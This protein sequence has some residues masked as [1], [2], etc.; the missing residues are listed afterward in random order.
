MSEENSG[1]DLSG[2]KLVESGP[3][4][5]LLRLPS[6][7]NNG[8]P[9]PALIMMHGRGANQ[10]DIY[11]LVPYVDKRVLVAAPRAPLLFSDDPRGSFMW[12]ETAGPGKAAPGTMEAAL[13]KL[14]AF[15]GQLEQSAGV[16][17]DRN[18]LYIGG[19]SQGAVMSYVLASARPDLVAG[20]IA[21]SGPFSDE[22]EKRLREAGSKLSGKPFFIA[23]G[24][25][26]DMV[27]PSHSQ[28]AASVLR[29]LGADVT[30]KEYPL[31]HETSVPSRHDLADWL[32]SRLK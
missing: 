28:S 7:K 27:P 15:I 13:D 14:L 18:Q 23:H 17:I 10:G 2:T 16:G 12:Y 9:F 4:T 30:Y 21:H 32:N 8:Q 29:E 3:L 25:K 31:A 5:Y 1:P 11:E 20:I 22:V 24:T 26:D 6:Q 19:F